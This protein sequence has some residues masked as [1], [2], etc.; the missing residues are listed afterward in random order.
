[1]LILAFTSHHLRD[2][3]RRGIW[4][5]P[6]TNTQPLGKFVYVTLICM[7]PYVFAFMFNYTK[8]VFSHKV[9]QYSIV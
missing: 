5:Y 8:P 6:Y 3:N 7:L 1:M 4:L 2:G 9:V